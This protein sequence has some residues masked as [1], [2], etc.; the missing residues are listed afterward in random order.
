M[1]NI[2]KREQQ[3]TI[4]QFFFQTVLCMGILDDTNQ[5]PSDIVTV[6]KAWR[7]DG[8]TTSLESYRI[9]RQSDH[10]I[11]STINV[12]KN[13]IVVVAC[14]FTP[15]KPIYK[16]SLSC[17]SILGLRS[18]VQC[19]STHLTRHGYNTVVVLRGLN[20]TNQH[21]TPTE[22]KKSAQRDANTARALTVVR[23]GHRPPA[24]NK[25]THKQTG[26]IT[27]HCAV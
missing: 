20:L 7:G 12:S 3:W 24:T 10:V 6:G 25:Q 4:A 22:M 9:V 8:I 5:R 13:S 23:F 21:Q 2:Q 19:Y 11:V 14:R 1:W 16:L 15:T 17:A 26:P 27:I 18:G